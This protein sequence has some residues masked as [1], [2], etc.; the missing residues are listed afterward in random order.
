VAK[1]APVISSTLFFVVVLGLLGLYTYNTVRP[2]LV[3]V[4]TTATVENKIAESDCKCA[5]GLLGIG[6]KL[7]LTEGKKRQS[8]TYYL[9]ANGN[10]ITLRSNKNHRIGEF[11]KIVFVKS[12][13]SSSQFVSNSINDRPWIIFLLFAVSVLISYKTFRHDLR[14]YREQSAA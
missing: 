6:C 11:V 8:Y 3:G 12:D 5:K 14:R 10:R 4:K 9:D 2:E 13:P 1:I 7:G